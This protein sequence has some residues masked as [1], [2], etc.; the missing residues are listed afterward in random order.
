MKMIL[1]TART[2]DEY[3]ACLQGWQARYA[4]ALRGAVQ[5]AAPN[6][7]E[8][9]K[10]GHAVYFLQGP[11]LLIRAEPTRVLFSFWHGQRLRGI[12]PRLAPGGKYEMATLV[13][14]EETPLRRETVT[15]L[16]LE[17]CHLNQR[18]GDPTTLPRPD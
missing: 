17:A 13:L 4:S 15:A 14:K 11:V 1:T 9:L 8:R 2:A 12:E 6:L 16:A 7:A 3:F 18:L 10:W 5:Q